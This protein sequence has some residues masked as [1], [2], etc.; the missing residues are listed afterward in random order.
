MSSLEQTTLARASVGDTLEPGDGAGQ[1][2]ANLDLRRTRTPERTPVWYT[3]LAVAASW[4]V[5]GAVTRLWPN[6]IT[7]F[8][9]WA[10]TA[11]LGAAAWVVAAWI[12]L[13]ALTLPAIERASIRL[14]PALRGLRKAGPWL[15]ALPLAFTLWEILTAK[16]A[17]LP[18]PFF[19]PPQALIEVYHDDWARLADCVVHS[20][21]LLAAGFLYGGVVGFLVGVSIGWSRAV[22]YWV[23]PVLR[24]LGPV[25]A[26]ALLPLAF[27]IFP[28]SRSAAIFLVALATAFPVTVLTWSGVASVNKAY[29][30]VART[31]GASPR[32]LVLRV[33]IPAALPQVFVG[34]F[35]GLSASFTVLVTAEMMGVKSG[36][37][38]YLTWAQG[39]ASYSNMYAA[40]LVMAILFSGLISLLFLVR[41]RTLVWQKGTVKW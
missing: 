31:L 4:A 37:G 14:R 33:A 13:I 27:Y 36:L 12:A 1:R 40:L 32:F 19:A 9:D 39:W 30:D 29:Y 20:L 26:T 5:F 16:T 23:H 10:Y 18:T 35:M 34:L 6:H 3:G 41:D 25:P 11:E 22:G 7:G 21:G 38:W 28:S 15:V 24:V 2:F 17:V 8:S